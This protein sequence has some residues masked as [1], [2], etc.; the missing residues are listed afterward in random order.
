MSVDADPKVHQF[1]GTVALAAENCR[2]HEALLGFL[3]LGNKLK[4]NTSVM[5]HTRGPRQPTKSQFVSSPP[6][7]TLR[8]SKER[9]M[10]PFHPEALFF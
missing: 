2:W 7:K 10:P 4:P 3:Q 1:V 6:N 5:V 9:I 8:V